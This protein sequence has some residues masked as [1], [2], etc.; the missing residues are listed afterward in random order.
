MISFFPVC[1]VVNKLNIFSASSSYTISCPWILLNAMFC[2]WTLCLVQVSIAI[3]NSIFF[4]FSSF[5]MFVAITKQCQLAIDGSFHLV[6]PG[7]SANQAIELL[8]S[9]GVPEDRIIF[10]TLVSVK[11]P[12]L[13]YRWAIPPSLCSF[14]LVSLS[15]SQTGP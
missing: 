4:I 6:S 9:K 10:L 7:N 5:G 12:L 8:M 1:G 14:W 3:H 13:S 15:L 11:F 2:F